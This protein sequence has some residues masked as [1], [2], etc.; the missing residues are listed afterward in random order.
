MPL[1]PIMNKSLAV[2]Y[3]VF[4][5]LMLCSALASLTQNST[6]GILIFIFLAAWSAYMAFRRWKGSSAIPQQHNSID[7]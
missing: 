1:K 3:A 6:A 5:L 2:L 7:Q 4:S